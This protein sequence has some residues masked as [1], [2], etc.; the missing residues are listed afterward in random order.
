MPTST[1][2][3]AAS[4][5]EHLYNEAGIQLK[6]RPVGIVDA[7]RVARTQR[8]AE[9]EPQLL[10]QSPSLQEVPLEVAQKLPQQL[11]QLQRNSQQ[12]IDLGNV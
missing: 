3:A 7:M 2:V 4:L 8:E 10:A 12:L 9:R 5:P 1:Q 11:E 6:T